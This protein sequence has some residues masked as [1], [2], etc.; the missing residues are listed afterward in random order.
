MK[1]E[2]DFT[3]EQ[4]EMLSKASAEEVKKWMNFDP[5]NTNPNTEQVRA[6]K[7][8]LHEEGGEGSSKKK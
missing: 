6:S 8:S 5:E 4:I 3:L 7:R 1:D 2:R